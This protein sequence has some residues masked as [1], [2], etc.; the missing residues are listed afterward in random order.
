LASNAQMTGMM[1][2]YLA[3]AELSLKGWIVSPT[4]RSA[5][6]A[7]LMVTDPLCR[8]AWSVQVKTQRA[9]KP[10]WNLHK[11]AGQMKSKS[12]LYI[13]IQLKA[14]GNLRPDYFILRSETVVER[15]EV[16]WKKEMLDGNKIQDGK[17]KWALFGDPQS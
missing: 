7:D 11:A 15:M 13:F 14:D 4:S 17:E 8:H 12:L 9:K 10:F 16:K 5:A 2:V 6:G 1:G 3:A